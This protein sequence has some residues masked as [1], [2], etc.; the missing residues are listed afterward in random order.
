MSR[1]F[2]AASS[3][4][5]TVAEA[6]VTTPP[7][8]VSFFF[9][10]TTVGVA[11]TMFWL[12]DASSSSSYFSVELDASDQLLGRALSGVTNRVVT[13][14]A[15]VTVD[16]W[17][18]ALA[19]FATTTLR[20]ISLDGQAEAANTQ[21]VNPSGIDSMAFAR[22]SDSSPNQ[23]FDGHLM[24]AAIW[25]VA[26]V[27]GEYEILSDRKCPLYFRRD[28]LVDFYPLLADEDVDI[29]NRRQLTANNTPTI[30]T[31]NPT[32][33]DGNMYETPADYW[34]YGPEKMTHSARVA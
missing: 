12:G 5:L 1:V 23:Y 7:F 2:T 32:R 20:Q 22:N 28:E 30:S 13:T 24:W 19:V 34:T 29:I 33:T 9:Q 17:H 16:T 21:L 31:D 4:S 8:A 11:Q 27:D 10:P 14:V 3:E 26:F 18:H 15:T 6:P 25:N